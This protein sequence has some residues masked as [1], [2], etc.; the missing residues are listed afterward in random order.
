M[1]SLWEGS[2]VPCNLY[3][4]TPG[5]VHTRRV[6]HQGRRTVLGVPRSVGTSANRE[7]ATPP[8]AAL[9]CLA[10]DPAILLIMVGI[11]MFLLTFCGCI[12]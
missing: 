5:K 10:V 4:A 12:R 9:A 1:F 7:A 11:L 6:P 8:E 2:S 3:L